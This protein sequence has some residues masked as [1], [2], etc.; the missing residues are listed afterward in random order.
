MKNST[1]IHSH[2]LATVLFWA[3]KISFGLVF[4]H[5]SH[6][7][8]NSRLLQ[9]RFVIMILVYVIVKYKLALVKFQKRTARVILDC[10]FY[11]SYHN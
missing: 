10:D 2:S 5:S 3:S 7:D 6:L 4:F 8:T 11:T 9:I 1:S